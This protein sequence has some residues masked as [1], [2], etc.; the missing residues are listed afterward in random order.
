MICVYSAY[1]LAFAIF[2]ISVTGL[3]VLEAITS[4]NICSSLL[5]AYDRS[6]FCQSHQMLM[7]ASTLGAWCIL[8]GLHML[9]LSQLYKV[10]WWVDRL[11]EVKPR[12]PPKRIDF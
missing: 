9:V 3:V 8:A 7:K 11:E 2:E 5:L 1:S 10:F 6:S 4:K 12:T